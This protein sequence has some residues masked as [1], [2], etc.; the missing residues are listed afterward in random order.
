MRRLAVAILLLSAVAACSGI[1]VYDGERSL[2]RR[3]IAPGP[4]LF[5][6]PAGRWTIL[7]RDLSNADDPAAGNHTT[8]GTMAP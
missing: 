6:G 3:E 5:T 2:N 1:D 4:G 8:E 7:R